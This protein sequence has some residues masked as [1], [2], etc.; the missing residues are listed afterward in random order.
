MDATLA[1]AAKLAGSGGRVSI[2]GVGGGTIAMG[3][4]TF[5]PEVSVVAPRWGTIPE[6]VEVVALAQAGVLD[7]HVERI[8]L[9][10]ASRP[11]PGCARAR[12]SAGR[13]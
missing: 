8:G 9:D 4:G 2:V 12:S 5:R 11:T 1:L 3:F 10:D 6:L 7:V 13:W